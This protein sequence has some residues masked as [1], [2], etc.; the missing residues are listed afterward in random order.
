ME[1]WADS[2]VMFEAIFQNDSLADR[3]L[4]GV[5]G[6]LADEIWQ[7]PNCPNTQRGCSFLSNGFALLLNATQP[8]HT[9][10]KPDIPPMFAIGT[11]MSNVGADS[12]RRLHP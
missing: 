7:A 10:S 8:H 11:V 9:I 1:A 3:S 2:G 6:L 5:Q 4:T 12:D